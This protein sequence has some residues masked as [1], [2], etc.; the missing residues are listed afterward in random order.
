MWRVRR[1]FLGVWSAP[2]EVEFLR[3][4]VVWEI[5]RVQP[6]QTSL[7]L[8]VWQRPVRFSG[9][10]AAAGA[11]LLVDRSSTPVFPEGIGYFILFFGWLKSCGGESVECR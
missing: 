9:C 6:N 8:S 1:S 5:P 10:G 3:V 2:C 4:Y 11:Q 7:G